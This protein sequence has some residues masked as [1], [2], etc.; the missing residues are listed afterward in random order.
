[1]PA[2]EPNRKS[3]FVVMPIKREGSAEYVHFRALYDEFLRPALEGVGYVVQRSD[4]VQKTGAITKD[5]ILALASVDLVVADLTDLNPNVFYELGVR[6]SLRGHGT[7]MIVDDA[8][9]TDIPFD[10]S[11][12]RVIK[13]KGELAGFG[14]LR[15]EIIAAI[16]ALDEEDLARRDNPVHDWIPALPLNALTSS[17]RSSEGEL[18]AR[19]ARAQQTIK[20]YEERYGIAKAAHDASNSPLSVVLDALADA[21]EQRLP[22]D[23]VREAEEASSERDVERFLSIVRKVMEKTRLR[24]SARQLETLAIFS[25]SLGLDTVAG[26]IFDHATNLHPRDAE[27]RRSQLAHFAHSDDPAD[28]ERARQEFLTDI[29][30]TIGPNDVT[31]PNHVTE[32]TAA[33]LGVMLDAY[34][35][36]GMNDEALRITSAFVEQYPNMTLIA[37][38]HARSL[39]SVGRSDEALAWYERAIKCEDS[40]DTSAIWFGNELHNRRRPLD[41]IEAYSRACVLDPDDARGFA[42]VANEMSAF[43]H[44]EA[45][46]VLRSASRTVPAALSLDAIERSLIAAFSC[47]HFNQKDLDRC[48]ETARRSGIELESLI[49]MRQGIEIDGKAP[50]RRMSI[51]ERVEL[52]RS[53][54][55]AFKSELTSTGV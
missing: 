2:A 37:R 42:Y 48:H 8:R 27:L 13:F 40:N 33:T 5:I 47:R 12:Y 18:R 46:G 50:S 41:A 51:V 54:Y 6:H 11:A 29:G 26:A 49:Q 45:R 53:I 52:A 22:S 31:I 32:D 35:S 7:I 36:D 34:L 43:L 3:C 16:D 4:D 19:L 15:R 28:R 23:L 25:S 38:N 17:L 44:D 39:E 9:T 1:M 20:E 24:M 30:L 21:S 14:R 55:A 10:L